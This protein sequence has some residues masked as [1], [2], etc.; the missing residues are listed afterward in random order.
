MAAKVISEPQLRLLKELFSSSNGLSAYSL[1]K[2]SKYPFSDFMKA[3]S[4]LLSE[5]LVA[6][7]KDDFFKITTNGIEVVTSTSVNKQNTDWRDVPLEM[8]GEKISIESFYTPS[9]SALDMR[10]FNFAKGSVR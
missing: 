1:F 7:E 9:L 8:Q 3:V 5:E 6:E 2:R 10:S 4:A